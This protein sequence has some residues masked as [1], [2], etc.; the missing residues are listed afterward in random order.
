MIEVL[1]RNNKNG[2]Q[3]YMNARVIFQS[4]KMRYPDYIVLNNHNQ[5]V[6]GS[7]NLALTVDSLN[8]ERR[9]SQLNRSKRTYYL[10]YRTEFGGYKRLPA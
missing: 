3:T 2:T 1:L 10:A 9:F 5:F 8:R 7:N 4:M 6:S